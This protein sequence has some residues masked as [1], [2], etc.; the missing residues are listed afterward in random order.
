MEVLV[1]VNV[2]LPLADPCHVHREIAS[3]WLNGLSE[4]KS[5]LIC[6]VVQ[7]GVLRLLTTSS[8]MQGEPL[9]LP[10]AWSW[11]GKLIQDPCV[12]GIQEPKGLQAKWAELCFDFGASPK[13]V[14]DAYLAAFAIAGGHSLVTFD[15]GFK[16]F[17]GLELELLRI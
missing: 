9:T 6:R 16:Q 15:K 1:D 5:L 10:E 17:E 2:L 7:M 4:N 3:K 13:I 8:V 14:T 12:S 11:Y